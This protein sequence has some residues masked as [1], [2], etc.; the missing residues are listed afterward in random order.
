[1]FHWLTT[2]QFSW[3]CLLLPWS[4]RRFVSVWP[5]W[6]FPYH[7]IYVGTSPTYINIH[8]NPPKRELVYATWE[9]STLPPC[10]PHGGFTGCVHAP[11][12][13]STLPVRSCLLIKWNSRGIRLTRLCGQ[14]CKSRSQAALQRSVLNRHRQ[15]TT[16]RL[17]LDASKKFA[18]S[19][20]KHYH[21]HGILV[22]QK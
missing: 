19:H 8:S 5:S 11:L 9:H 22:T 21:Y 2:I 17:K 16:S 12:T 7:T 15:G 18:R 3:S 1:M 13:I 6:G 14:Y 4:K 20:I 10:A